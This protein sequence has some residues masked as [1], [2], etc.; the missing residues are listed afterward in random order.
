MKNAYLLIGIRFSVFYKLLSRNKISFSPKYLLRFLI[1]FNESIFNAFFTWIENRRYKKKLAKHLVPLNPIFIVGHWRTG[2]TFLHQLLS[3]DEQFTTTSLFQVAKPD[4]FVSSRRYYKPIMS[5]FLGGKRPFD[6]VKTGFDEPQED[7]FALLR[8]TSYSPLEGLIFPKT[9][10]YF[11]TYF[12]DLMPEN[13]QIPTWEKAIKDFYKKLTFFDYNKRLL[14]KNPFHS[15]RIPILKKLFPD[16]KFIHIYRHPVDVV[17]STIKMWTTVCRQNTMNNILKFPEFSEVTDYLIQMENKIFTDLSILAESDYCE[18][19]YEN[20][21]KD[22]VSEIENV[23]K[24]L[25][26]EMNINTINKIHN[27][28][29]E[30]G[31]FKKNE[32]HLNKKEQDYIFKMMK[33]GFFS[34]KYYSKI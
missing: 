19:K 27:F 21:E 2:S 7:E 16:A 4:S 32:H 14:I 20:L 28:L 11:L 12:P 31:A 10:N 15:M 24:K 23:Y 3:L 9:Q 8:L 34:G 29:K 33:T 22:P 30:I 17:P 1:I 5:L 18:I 13:E 6:Q 25:G 26:I